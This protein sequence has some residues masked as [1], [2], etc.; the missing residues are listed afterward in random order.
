[1]PFNPGQPGVTVPPIPTRPTLTADELKAFAAALQQ[2]DAIVVNATQA[3]AIQKALPELAG[4]LK[5]RER[6]LPTDRPRCSQFDDGSLRP[7]FC[8]PGR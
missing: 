1:L 5:I 7:M 4:K 2:L 8:V 6:Y 3:E